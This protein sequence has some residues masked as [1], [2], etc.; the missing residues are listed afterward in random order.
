[1]VHT[2]SHELG[3][4]GLQRVD[5][6]STSEG[7]MLLIDFRTLAIITGQGA[8]TTAFLPMMIGGYLRGF[9]YDMY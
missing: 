8:V 3:H 9:E 7:Q 6:R 5:G 4:I 2:P 1:M